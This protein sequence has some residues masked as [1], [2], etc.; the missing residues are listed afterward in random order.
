MVVMA[1]PAFAQP[2]QAFLEAAERSNLDTRTSVQAR[3]RAQADF[4]QAWGGL[5]PSLTANGGWTHN[6]YEAI[7]DFGRQHRHHHPEE[8]ARARPSRPRCR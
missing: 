2:L 5:L 3:E 8:P 7:V 1:A 6:Q 4:A